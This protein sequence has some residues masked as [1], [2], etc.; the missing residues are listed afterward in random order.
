LT[1]SVGANETI[2]V[3]QAFVAEMASQAAS[4]GGSQKIYVKGNF[5]TTVKSDTIAIG[6]ALLEQV[7]NP[8]TGATNLATAAAL[9][10]VGSLG[11]LGPYLSAAGGLAL[12]AYQGYK[13]GGAKGAEKALAMGV[14]GM[15]LGMIPG[16][17]ALMATVTD[18]ASPAP[19]HDKNAP[20]GAE[21]AGGGAGGD[22]AD[23]AAAK[24]PG[25]GHRN[26]I[27][28]G[29]MNELVGATYTV[30]SP[31]F[32]GWKTTGMS[33]FVVGGSHTTKTR[34]F[35]QK[36]LGVSTETLGALHVTSDQNIVRVVTGS[37]AT[38]IGGALNSTSSGPHNIK[39]T[40]DLTI[41]V[42]GSMKMT[43]SVVAFICGSS[44][45]A[46]SPGGVLIEASD[47]TVTGDSKQS[48]DTA[49]R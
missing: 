39:A 26:Q 10:G 21:E 11:K 45:V 38:N 17:D 6:A 36:V 27:V 7:G 23:H 41:K 16:G 24:G 32:I 35:T 30:A 8:V 49:H 9:Q 14:A 2:S 43:G 3:K 22:A 46:A 25:P 13:Q 48:S 28:H 5:T 34:G 44:K 20:A 4:V 18:A 12:G 33:S 19:W 1:R 15:G 42:G 29:M 40:G 37:L 31:G 47:I